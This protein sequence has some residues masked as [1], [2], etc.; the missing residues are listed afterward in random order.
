MITCS[1]IFLGID[2]SNLCAFIIS[3]IVLQKFIARFDRK[4][5]GENKERHKKEGERGEER[6]EEGRGGEGR[7]HNEPS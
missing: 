1:S 5:V 7:R 6:G 4:K 2:D 3:F